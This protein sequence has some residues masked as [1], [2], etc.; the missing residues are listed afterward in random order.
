MTRRMV[1]KNC[2]IPWNEKESQSRVE[3]LFPYPLPWPLYFSRSCPAGSWSLSTMDFHRD[4]IRF[5]KL[6][7]WVFL[8]SSVWLSQIG[9]G[10]RCMKLARQ[11]Q[12]LSCVPY[13]CSTFITCWDC[14]CAS[15]MPATSESR[16]RVS[17]NWHY[18]CSIMVFWNSCPGS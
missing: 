12:P 11:K 9:F 10:G 18:R 17:A 6:R 14:M 4:D 16:R 15:E 8:F 1:K 5:S 7:T 2:M 13:L 3:R